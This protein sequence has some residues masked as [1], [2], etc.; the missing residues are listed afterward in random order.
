MNEV[1]TI[2]G[3]PLV[4]ANPQKPN[5]LIS[6]I[7]RI[8][9]DPSIPL[10][11]IEHSLAI[12]ERLKSQQNREAFDDAVAA[13][14]AE[15]PVIEKNRTGHNS[16]RYADLSAYVRVIDPV[17]SRHGLKY[18]WRTTQD[19]RINVT[20][21]LSGHGHYEENSLSGPA[22]KTGSK[23]DI[24]AI[25]STLTYLQRYT[26]TQALG[27][28][29]SE[30]DDGKAAGVGVAINDEQCA[31][32]TSLG[33][34]IGIQIDKFCKYMKVASLADIPASRYDDAVAAMESKRPKQ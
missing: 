29:A 17:L 21:I 9:R 26:L 15:I 4:E 13:A 33:A 32:L 7:E 1:A 28:A 8:I 34:E 10:D 14:K 11:R 20:C 6:V 2:T 25:G 31:K 3:R 19:D 24:Q 18:R 27:L 5:A 12:Y 30:D 16:K 22:D 23:N